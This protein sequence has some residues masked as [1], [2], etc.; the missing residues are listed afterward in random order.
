MQKYDKNSTIENWK[1]YKQYKKYYKTF[2]YLGV[3][4]NYN[5]RHNNKLTNDTTDRQNNNCK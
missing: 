5:G 3:S 1:S 4:G 2:V